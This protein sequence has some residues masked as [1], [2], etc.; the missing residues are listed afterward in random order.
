L[1]ILLSLYNKTNKFIQMKKMF[2]IGLLALAISASAEAK[3]VGKLKKT[4][5]SE[6]SK[7]V[8]SNFDCTGG[9]T[10]C[11]T[12][13]M[14]CGGSFSDAAALHFGTRMI[15]LIVVNYNEQI[16]VNSQINPYWI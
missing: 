6:K 4:T 12:S 2:T 13:Y 16:R 1:K 15:R 10:S 11:G 7:K 8:I 9:M 3:T 14:F 5:K